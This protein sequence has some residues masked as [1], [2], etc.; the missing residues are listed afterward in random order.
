MIRRSSRINGG[1]KLREKRRVK[2]VTDNAPFD[3]CILESNSLR[4]FE[5][6]A[7]L[8]FFRLN[9]TEWLRFRTIPRRGF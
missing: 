4:R 1:E 3:D 7:S 9:S 2:W 8:R 6:S 5:F